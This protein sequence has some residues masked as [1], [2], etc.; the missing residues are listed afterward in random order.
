M[1]RTQNTT[2][3]L[4]AV[5]AIAANL[6]TSQAQ[7]GDGGAG[8]T[9]DP[10]PGGASVETGES[11]QSDFRLGSLYSD[12]YSDWTPALH[13]DLNYRNGS[14]ADWPERVMALS[15][16]AKGAIAA[17]RELNREP[18]RGSVGFYRMIMPR[19]EDELKG[20]NDPLVKGERPHSNPW[21][22]EYGLAGG[23]ETDQMLDHRNGTLSAYF[24]FF[25]PLNNDRLR[26]L[27][28]SMTAALDG[29][30]TD[31]SAIADS[32]EIERSDHLRLRLAV[33]WQLRM[34]VYTDAPVIKRFVL[35]SAAEY[36]REFGAPDGWENA[37]LDEAFGVFAEISYRLRTGT[38]DTTTSDHGRPITLFARSSFGRIAPQPEEDTSVLAGV[39]FSF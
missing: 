23:Y 31:E 29:V 5:L 14:A 16:S 18:L 24:N 11:W 30:F 38:E 13:F 34:S 10:G 7:D 9:F 20:W 8:V 33:D 21:M 15:F 32:M 19:F 6:A 4:V 1:K 17:D 27:L 39:R 2:R 28:P 35:H 3:H 12:D 22:L 26:S 37:G 36:T 25:A